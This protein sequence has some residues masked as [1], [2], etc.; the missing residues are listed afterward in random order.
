[1]GFRAK[2]IWYVFNWKLSFFPLVSKEPNTS[3]GL[4]LTFATYAKFVIKVSSFLFSVSMMHPVL[5]FLNC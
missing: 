5:Y 1:M 4:V 3:A 2:N